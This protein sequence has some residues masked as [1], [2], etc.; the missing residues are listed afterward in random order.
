MSITDTVF[1]SEKEKDINVNNF[2]RRAWKRIFSKINVRYRSTYH[3]RHTF[4]TICLKKGKTPQDIGKWVV[5]SARMIFEHYA[6]ISD[7]EV[8]DF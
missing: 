2:T 1:Y 6:G 8:P 4:I 5:N 3:C 7:D